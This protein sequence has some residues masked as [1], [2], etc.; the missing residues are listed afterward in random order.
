MIFFPGKILA[1]LLYTRYCAC[2]HKTFRGKGKDRKMECGECNKLL[3]VGSS[4][5]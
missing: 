1:S 3:A 2:M 4:A 5:S